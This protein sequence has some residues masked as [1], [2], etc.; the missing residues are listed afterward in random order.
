MDYIKVRNFFSSKDTMKRILRQAT[1]WEKMFADI[2]LTKDLY[3]EYERTLA[4]QKN[5]YPNRKR[6]EL[7]VHR[8]E[9]P[10]VQFVVVQSLSHVRLFA[11]PWTAGFPVLHCL[12]EFA[13]IHFHWADDAIQ[14][15]HPQASPSPL[16]L[17]LSQHQGLFQWVGSL[18]QVANKYRKMCSISLGLREMQINR[19]IQYHCTLE[20]EWLTQK[21]LIIPCVGDGMEWSVF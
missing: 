8:K 3:T 16:A 19:T 4:N 14:L 1:E 10:N 5:R 20:P 7:A 12:P 21:W 13:Q 6:L 17:S 11:S 9:R 2:C 18:H 15:S